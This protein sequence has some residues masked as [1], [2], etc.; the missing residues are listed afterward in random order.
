MYCEEHKTDNRYCDCQL[1]KCKQN[2]ET[3]EWVCES[4]DMKKELP[5]SIRQKILETAINLTKGDR[6]KTYGSPYNNL[7]CYARLCQ[8]YLDGKPDKELGQEI[9]PVD[10]AIFMVLA[11][12]SRV[13]AN[14]N[15]KD[16]Y[17]DGSAYFGI[18]GENAQLFQEGEK[19]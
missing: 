11:K 16:N 7:S 2:Q 6:N 5:K 10:A 12:V 9:T 13:A 19:W 18:A 17:V 1:Y 15:H 3:E 8:A 4:D 14:Y